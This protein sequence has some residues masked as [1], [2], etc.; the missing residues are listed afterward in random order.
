VV[1]GDLRGLRG[2]ERPGTQ[3]PTEREARAQRSG[4]AKRKFCRRFLVL[5]VTKLMKKKEMAE[6]IR[7]LTRNFNLPSCEDFKVMAS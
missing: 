1:V 2:F 5:G 4:Q 7:N 3:R 6:V